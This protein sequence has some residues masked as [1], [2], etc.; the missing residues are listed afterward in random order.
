MISRK[1]LCKKQKCPAGL[2]QKCQESCCDRP[3]HSPH[4]PHTSSL[5]PYL[6]I[7]LVPK[8][9]KDFLDGY[10]LASLPVHGLPHNAVGLQNAWVSLR[11]MEFLLHIHMYSSQSGCPIQLWILGG[12]RVRQ[13]WSDRA[14]N[15]QLYHVLEWERG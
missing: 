4:T 11:S 8:G 13:V 2:A 6:S 9:I 7:Y 12:V 15:N 1:V 3:S 10:Y 5:F 14:H